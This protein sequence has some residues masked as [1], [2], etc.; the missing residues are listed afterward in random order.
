MATMDGFSDLADFRHLPDP[1]PELSSQIPAFDDEPNEATERPAQYDAAWT[2]HWKCVKCESTNW[3]AVSSGWQ[4][5]EC[6]STEFYRPWL[7]SRRVT[8]TGTWLY[9]PHGHEAAP[10]PSSSSKSSRRRNRRRRHPGGSEPSDM[11]GR[12]QAEEEVLTHDPSVEPSIA[13]SQRDNV[14]QGH[15]PQGGSPARHHPAAQG[16]SHAHGSF[17]ASPTGRSPLAFGKGS[18]RDPLVAALRQLK[19]DDDTDWNSRKGPE[20]GIRWRTGQHPQPPSWKYD[21]NDLRA[22]AK[23]EKK[24]RI[25][26]IQM[27]PY[28]SKSD[29]ALLLYG[30]LTGDAE[31]ELEHLP[32]DEVHQPNGIQVILDRLKTPFEQRTVFQKRKFLHEFES[33]R[34]YPNEVLRIYIH[35]FRRAIRNLKSVGVDITATYDSEALGARLLDRSGLSAEAQRMILVGT[36]QSLNMESISEALV[37]QYPDFRGAPPIQGQKG[38]GKGKDGNGMAATTSSSS[39]TTRVNPGGKGRPQTS[40]VYVAGADD[41]SQPMESIGEGNEDDDDFA[42]QQPDDDEGDDLDQ[43][44][45]DDNDAESLDLGELSHVLTVTAKKLAGM[46]L[47]RKFTTKKPQSSQAAAAIAKKKANS[48]CAACGQKG[49]WKG[50]AS[51]PMTTTSRP[52]SSADT[53]GD[54][55]QKPFQ[56]AGS[57]KSRAFTVVHHDHGSLEVN[58]DDEYGNMFQ[59]MMVSG[60]QQFMVHEVQAFS[61]TDFVGKLIIDS[62]CQRNCCGMDWY[63]GHTQKLSQMFGLQPT[64]IECNDSFQFGKG[65]PQVA[66]HRAYI[67]AGLSGMRCFLLGTAVLDAKVPLLG[68]HSLL[69]DL[70]AI[71]NLPEKKIHLLRLKVS[72]PLIL[73]SGHLA[74]DID[75]FPQEVLSRNHDCWKEFDDA[76]V[77]KNPNPNC[78]L[79]RVF[80]ARSHHDNDKHMLEVDHGTTDNSQDFQ[81]SVSHVAHTSAMADSLE[82]DGELPR[83][84]QEESLL[85]DG[86]R[87][88][89]RSDASKLV[90]RS[91]ATTPDF[92][93]P[94][95]Q[96]RPPEHQASRQC[97]RPIRSMP[98]LRDEVEVGQQLGEV[99]RF[100][101]L[102]KLLYTV[103]TI[104]I[105]VL[106]CNSLPPGQGGRQTQDQGHGKEQSGFGDGRA[107][108]ADYRGLDPTDWLGS[109][110]GTFCQEDVAVH[111][112]SQLLRSGSHHDRG[113]GSTDE[114]RHDRQHGRLRHREPTGHSEGHGNQQEDSRSF[115]KPQ[116]S[117]PSAS[118]PNQHGGGRGGLRLG[119]G[120]R[121]RSNMKKAVQNLEAESMIYQALPTVHQRPPPCIDVFEVFSGA[122]KFTLRCSKFGL[123]ALEPIDIQHGD[124]HD[125]KN[126]EVRNHIMKAVK[127]F[128]PWLVIL[129]V[130]CR[131]WNQFNINMNYSQ[132]PELLQSLQDEERPLVQFA[133]ELADFQL[134][135]NRYF[136]I[137]NPQRSQLWTLREVIELSQ[138]PD[139]WIQYLDTGAFG[140]QVNGHD[141]IKTMGFLG[142]IPG[143]EDVIGRR[144]SQD[145]RSQRRPIEGALT[146]PSQEYPDELVDTILS[147]MKKIIHR[148]EPH[149]FALHHVLPVAQPVADLTEWD[150]VVQHVSKT[151]ERANKRPFNIDPS[152][153]LGKKICDLARMNAVRIQCAY[154]PTTRRIPTALAFDSEVTSRAALLEYANGRRALEVDNI[155]ELQLPKQRFDT[156]VAVAI[157]MYG[158]LREEPPT[159]PT[160]TDEDAKLPLAD[161]PTDITFPGLP[162]GHGINVDTRRTV[163]RLHLNLGH[164]SPQELIR[165]VAYYGGAPSAIITCIQ[166]L[167]CSTCERL[168]SPQQPRPATMPKFIAGQFGDEVQGDLFYV[169][170][171]TGDAIPVLGL[172]DKATGYHQAAVCTTR[173]SAETFEIFVKCWFK[174]FGL[175][176]K[177]MLDPDTAFR[178]DCQRQIESLGIICDFCPAEAHWMIGMV[179]RRNSILRCILEKLIDQHASST[180]DELELLL[181]PAL[182]AVNSSTFTRGRTAF[183]AVFGRVPRLPGGLLTDETSLASSHG[184]LDQPDNLLAKAEIIRSEAQKYLM[185]LNINQ[186]LRRAI[187]RRTRNTKYVDLSPGQPCAFWRW[188]KKGQRK[189]GGWIVAKFLSWDPSAPSKLA[190]LRTGN[191]TTLVAAEQIRAAM[192]FE[193]WHPSEQ[194][195]RAL[196]DAE[197]SFQEHLLEDDIG[198][199]PPEDATEGDM[200]PMLEDVPILTAPAT[201]AAAPLQLPLPSQQPPIQQ[202]TTNIQQIT[203][204]HHQH[205]IHSPTYQQTQVYQRYGPPPKTPTR[206]RGRSRSPKPPALSVAQQ[207]SLPE[208][209]EQQVSQHAEQ[210]TQPL[211][212]Q[213]GEETQ[214]PA[215]T[216]QHEAQQ[217]P[218][219]QQHTTIATAAEVITIPDDNDVE[220]VSHGTLPKQTVSQGI[221]PTQQAASSDRPS[222]QQEVGMETTALPQKRTFEQLVAFH[223]WEGTLLPERRQSDGSP[224]LGYGHF[225]DGYFRAYAASEQRKLDLEGTHKAFD[226]MDTSDDSSDDDQP[227]LSSSTSTSTNQPSLQSTTSSTPTSPSS[228]LPPHQRLT[229]QEAKQLDRELPWREIC[230]MPE[231]HIQ[232]FLEA[233]EKEAN[234]WSEWRSIQ[235]LTPAEA[236]KVR[237]DPSLRKRILRSR[238]AYRDKHRGQGQLKAKCRIVALGH[239]D[240]DIYDITRSSPTPGRA[241]EHIMF[242]MSVAGMNREILHSGLPWRVWLGDAQTAF[243]QGRQP[244]G[245]RKLPLFM[246]APRDPLIDRTPFWKDALY[247][248]T[249]N[250][251]G[252]PNAPYLWTEEVVGRLTSLNYVRHDFDRMLF[253][254]Y[255]D[256]NEIMSLI[257]CYVDDFYGIHRQDY[258]IGEVHQKFKWGELQFFEIDKPQTF[259]GKELCYKLNKENRVVLHIS[260]KK[261]LETVEPYELPRGRMKQPEVLT[262]DEQK[263]F[264]SIAGC[265]QWLGSQTRPDVSPAI[266]LCNHGQQTTIHD[267]KALAETLQHAKNTQELGL[268]IQ[269]VPVNKES[270]L[271]TYTDASWANAAH[272]T[273]Q[274]GIL[275]TL[276]TPDVTSKV[277]KA[278]LLDWRS[279]RS[280]RVCR[281][282]LASEASAADEGSD[283]S[284]YLNMMLSEI[285]FCEPAHRAGC[286]LD[287]LQATDAKSLYDALLAVNSTLTDKRSLVNIRAIQETLGPKQTRWIPTDLM[288]AD[289]LTKMNPI[290][291]DNLLRWLQYP[292]IQVIETP[293]D[294]SKV[295]KKIDE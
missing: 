221:L 197:K 219:Q 138:R 250:I 85:P 134:Y 240:P 193:N 161:L 21:Q 26:E 202:T 140:A 71:I 126:E 196:K 49:H 293:A 109:P 258:D 243:L 165:M 12:E 229:R 76:G 208:A 118:L 279:A 267:L 34:R 108:P 32:I 55:P 163:A 90:A 67:P 270:V 238:A 281:S 62:G 30:S 53:K 115:R 257:I 282:T 98:R 233:I 117:Q 19:K 231:A 274:M 290:L 48:H 29:Q 266:S 22:Y 86:R 58:N 33:L 230:G 111:L 150:D 141:I 103:A 283:R 155:L 124:Q 104:A 128:K 102:T 106:D 213:G 129:G 122:A 216:P 252:L 260:M 186:Q 3:I 203:H 97:T 116:S 212:Q 77:W 251:Y 164:P 10:S 139:V 41:A 275:V 215:A 142:N 131:F 205:N 289:G 239:N 54:R 88:E 224:D 204:E 285:L 180:T 24:V 159:R 13:A 278:A 5:E 244:D 82:E 17:G 11:E 101:W 59:C 192:G 179:E 65:K 100:P 158:T 113:R 125:L 73:V 256:C 237:A 152:S 91:S 83:Q 295:Q 112:E 20:P 249:G 57:Q 172:V 167:K 235:P 9:M 272:S 253:L 7:P 127:K 137:E 95:K 174:P 254:K 227:P 133:C 187:L 63:H 184:A 183:Q 223:V 75:D 211:E 38:A 168:K 178:G 201:P 14:P 284:A 96:M 177:M 136:L 43:P 64:T 263:E 191:S 226:E 37:L 68:S 280:P 72:L 121:L 36:H 271:M 255:D 207:A 288:H 119:V 206:H 110:T 247:R 242:V 87:S 241:T 245:E 35:R 79:P 8:D 56:S 294:R 28:A 189:R 157:F 16:G 261:F 50:D 173:N 23:Y 78:I 269:D 268:V 209:T 143:L 182:H 61:P 171:L 220:E 146:R 190:W 234:S 151:F 69:Q 105:T 169:R 149:R 195:I 51:C 175:P 70:E 44:A 232:K 60:P 265:L 246:S 156:P 31:Q 287:N 262:P 1:E 25:W 6:G 153:D 80:H 264:R 144:L 74:I 286:R 276:T 291:R 277:T 188:Q 222:Q 148:L 52:S 81:K 176:Y 135:H 84:L 259:K 130:D 107:L 210:S 170:L 93:E 27:Q 218:E 154:T 120:R 40:R 47:G 214:Q 236:A 292:T 94:P 145:E 45:D 89:A 198:P 2:P 46:T 66:V 4:C 273:S 228:P 92:E 42:D 185:D 166:H 132:R 248:V 225:S 162:S 199:P 123:N 39:S 99:G 181:A 194:D 200:I 160:A 18:A 147:F 114:A 15:S 217:Q